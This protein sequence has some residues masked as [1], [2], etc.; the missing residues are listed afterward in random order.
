VLDPI[1]GTSLF[2]R[3][4]PT[5]S[6]QLAVED[7]DGPAVGVIGYP[8]I[9]EVTYAGRGLGCWQRVGEAQPRRVQVNQTARMRGATV[10]MLNPMTWSESLLVTLHR[11]LLVL[12]LMKGA[13]DVAAGISD[14]MVIAGFPMGYE[15]LAPL[16]VIIGEA[17]GRIT[18][19]A[20][21]HVFA[22]DGTA[23][24]SNGR[25]HD[26]LLELVDGIEHGRDF[27]ALLPR[28]D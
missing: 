9:D 22:G 25:L 24:V 28:G 3:R 23:L 21:R 26:S 17:G 10:E 14:A 13:V 1:N 5:F 27:R 20:G 18:D 12:P 16:P 19:L 4:M 11:E 15:D 8:V 2:V 6:I 7:S